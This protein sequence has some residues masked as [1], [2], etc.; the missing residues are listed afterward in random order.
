MIY[1][2]NGK[3]TCNM[4]INCL[5][6]QPEN[7]WIGWQQSWTCRKQN[8]TYNTCINWNCGGRWVRKHFWSND[9]RHCE[10]VCRPLNDTNALWKNQSGSEDSVSTLSDSRN[11]HKLGCRQ[12]YNISVQLVCVLTGNSGAGRCMS[13]VLVLLVQDVGYDWG[14]LHRMRPEQ[15]FLIWHNYWESDASG[16]GFYSLT[17]RYL[18]ILR[19]P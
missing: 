17:L 5:Q 14:Y 16:I 15:T 12:M 1:K 9:N 2:H 7:N 4:Y 10:F 18:Y 19:E 8:W 6:M 13:H 11:A 3:E